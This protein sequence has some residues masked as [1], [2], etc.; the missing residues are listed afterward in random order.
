MNFKKIANHVGSI[1]DSIRNKFFQIYD[2][3]IKS[4]LEY[5]YSDLISMLENNIS[6]N[7]L[8]MTAQN[9]AGKQNRAGNIEEFKSETIGDI[10]GISKEVLSNFQKRKKNRKVTSRYKDY[11]KTQQSY[12]DTEKDFENLF[13]SFTKQWDDSAIHVEA[14][15]ICSA[16]KKNRREMLMHFRTNNLPEREVYIKSHPE[17]FVAML[18]IFLILLAEVAVN[19]WA[20][21][22][23]FS[24]GASESIPAVLVVSL[25]NTLIPFAF[26]QW[27]S[28]RNNR[29]ILSN[30]ITPIFYGAVLTIWF[31]INAV[32]AKMKILAELYQINAVDYFPQQIMMESANISGIETL[33]SFSTLQIF[34]VAFIALGFSYHHG[35]YWRD[36]DPMAHKLKVVE[37]KNTSLFRSLC[38][39]AKDNIEALNGDFDIELVYK[40]RNILRQQNFIHDIY[41]MLLVQQT[42]FEHFKTRLIN[43]ALEQFNYAAD[44]YDIQNG[45]EQINESFKISAATE[46]KES[47]GRSLG[48]LGA[49]F[50]LDEQILTKPQAI[51]ESLLSDLKYDY[52]RRMDDYGKDEKQKI[53][54][55]QIDFQCIQND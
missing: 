44:I 9:R 24:G 20:L 19:T 5:D 52:E 18:A 40:K 48:S 46:L 16:Q 39:D 32:L 22:E 23:V 6:R 41:E 38:K 31:Y 27:M 29:T 15:Q 35:K 45:G 21:K 1:W 12:G 17:R 7:K 54:H 30:I 3:Y 25:F 13:G 33:I 11:L 53:D 2:L 37:N 4:R 42:Q 43:K 55:Q 26:A 36:S 28:S 47:L 14:T 51:Q 50:N 49:T 8:E 10:I 34:I